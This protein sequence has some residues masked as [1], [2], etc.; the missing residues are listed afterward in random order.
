MNYWKK[1]VPGSV[2]ITWGN[3]QK[4]A[5]RRGIFEFSREKIE[6]SRRRGE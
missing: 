5:A 2:E 4:K 3:I 6:K 1:E